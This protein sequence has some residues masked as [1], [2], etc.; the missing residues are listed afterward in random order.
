MGLV[1]GLVLAFILG[2]GLH[3]GAKIFTKNANVLHLIQIGIPVIIHFQIGKDIGN[4][5]FQP[6]GRLTLM[7]IF[8]PICGS[9]STLEFFSICI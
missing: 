5:C 3:F 4:L 1:L 6:P 8:L 2:T 7:F 9:H